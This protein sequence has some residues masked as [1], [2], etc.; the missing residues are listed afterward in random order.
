MAYLNL[1]SITLRCSEAI[2]GVHVTYKSVQS[3]VS[4]MVH[5][6][7]CSIPGEKFQRK[8]Q[9]MRVPV[10]GEIFR[11]GCFN[12]S[13]CY[14]WECNSDKPQQACCCTLNQVYHKLDNFISLSVEHHLSLTEPEPGVD[15]CKHEQKTGDS[16]VGVRLIILII[17]TLLN[18]LPEKSLL[19]DATGTIHHLIRTPIGAELQQHDQI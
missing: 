16:R 12:G 9:L 8:I 10:H 17:V 4:Y 5:A 13:V 19:D 7:A 6:P 3:Y 11:E 18:D 2:H 1:I 15:T 14:T